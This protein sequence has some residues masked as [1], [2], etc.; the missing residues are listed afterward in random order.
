MVGESA[1]ERQAR[2]V[3]RE[4]KKRGWGEKG[5]WRRPQLSNLPHYALSGVKAQAFVRVL[6][7][8]GSGG[9]DLTQRF[10]RLADILKDR[11]RCNAFNKRLQKIRMYASPN[12]IPPPHGRRATTGGESR[13]K[14]SLFGLG[15]GATV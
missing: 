10:Q 12:A 7:D 5:A 4:R 15:V 1:C 11:I 6:F 13:G 9:C 14:K 8:I 2:P 3:G